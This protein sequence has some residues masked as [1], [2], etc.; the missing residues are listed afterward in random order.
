MVSVK[1]FV[2]DIRNDKEETV[3]ELMK[4][5]EIDR[6]TAEIQFER[7]IGDMVEAAIADGEVDPDLKD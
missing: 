1:Q 4:M 5:Y 7:M 2:A 6:H 3:P